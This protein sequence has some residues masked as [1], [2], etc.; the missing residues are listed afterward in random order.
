MTISMIIHVT[1]E[2]LNI[3]TNLAG[4]CDTTDT[5]VEQCSKA[6]TVCTADGGGG[7]CLCKATHYSDGTDCQT[8]KTYNQACSNTVTDTKQC[9]EAN[10]ECLLESGTSNYK[11]QCSAAY[12][13][14]GSG[15]TARIT[16]GNSCSANQC[17]EHAT[18]D[19]NCICEAGY[20]AS[21]TTNPT[22]CSGVVKF[23]S[24]SYM[25]VV[26]I[27]VSMMSLLR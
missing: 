3:V 22:M 17:V 14:N 15:C 16:P 27:L 10:Q 18:C 8:I 24:L 2:V 11:C 9:G 1:T 20:T 6:E 13:D 19:T 21:P 25:Y 7:K 4:T 26:P 23:A 12:Y 5:A